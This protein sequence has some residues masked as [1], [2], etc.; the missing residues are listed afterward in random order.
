MKNQIAKVEGYWASLIYYYLAGAGLEIIPEN[1]INIGQID[2]TLKAG[3]N[4]YIFEFKITNQDPLQQI[5]TKN[6]MRNI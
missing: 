1:V 6:T 4:I 3:E 2:F 5:K